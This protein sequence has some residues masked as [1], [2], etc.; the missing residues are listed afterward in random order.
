MLIFLTTNECEWTRINQFIR[1]HQRPFAVV[2]Y[3]L[4]FVVKP[5]KN[6]RNL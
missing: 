1:V 4:L 5:E 3:R 2:F 6:L